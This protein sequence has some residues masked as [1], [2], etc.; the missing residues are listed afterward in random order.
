M[1]ILIIEDDVFL[2]E[3]IGKIFASKVIANRIRIV[4]SF[5][6]FLN[7]LP[8]VSSYDIVLTDLQLS[9]D[10]FDLCGYRVIRAI[11]EKSATMP[12]VVI[13]GFADIDRLRV[14]F[15]YGAS[16]YLVKPVRLRELEL[17][18]LNWFKNYSLSNVAFSGHAHSYGHLKYDLDRNEFSF[19][20]D[21]I[22]LTK[23]NKYILSLFLSNPEKLLRESFL[24]EKI[25]GDICPTVNRN[26][27][28]SILRLKQSLCP[29]GIDEW[30]QNVRGEGYV[31]SNTEEPVTTRER[32]PDCRGF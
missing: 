6:E 3:K 11:R 12:I 19:K 24:V 5:L 21:P 20:N 27:R 31:F 22:P 25:W 30:I 17:R 26:L 7:E 28:V 13:S 14:A 15:E 29:F 9:Q 16:D 8:I 32:I 1:N 4:H 10:R 18:V 23:G 2:A